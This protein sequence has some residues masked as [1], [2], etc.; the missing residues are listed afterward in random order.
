MR[1]EA[2]GHV[3]RRDPVRKMDELIQR[4]PQI[5]LAQHIGEYGFALVEQSAVMLQIGKPLAGDEIA[6]TRVT[7][8]K[9]AG[10]LESLADR[11]GAH[12]THGIRP[13]F[14]AVEKFVELRVGIALFDLAA[15]EHE[16]ARDEID[17]VMALHHEDFEAAWCVPEQEYRGCGH[18]HRCGFFVLGHVSSLF[19]I[20]SNE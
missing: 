1:V 19:L 7:R 5:F 3:R 10:F 6:V 15:R 20:H 17:L 14:A 4:Q 12:C 8:Q 13:A 16:R 9:D 2:L 18:R 11:A